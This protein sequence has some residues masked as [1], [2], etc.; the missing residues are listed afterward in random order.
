MS[1]LNVLSMWRCVLQGRLPDKGWCELRNLQ[2]LELDYNDYEGML[3][4]CLAN[5]TPVQ[6]LSLSSNHFNGSISHISS[7]PS[8]KYL[9]LSNG[10][11]T[12]I[13]FSS[14]SNLSRLKILIIDNMVIDEENKSQP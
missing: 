10:H 4:L 6:L 7:L 1:S 13:L 3:P 12:P 2:E 8:L 11:F 9:D 5:M 14:F